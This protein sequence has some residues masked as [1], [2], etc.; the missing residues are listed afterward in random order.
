MKYEKK[1]QKKKAEHCSAFTLT[2]SSRV[3]RYNG[4]YILG[5]SIHSSHEGRYTTLA[6]DATNGDISIHSSHEGR[7]DAAYQNFI[8][9][10]HFNPLIP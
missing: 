7:Y 10:V 1:K 4:K 5:I 2:H 8:F 9:T 3:G 6:P